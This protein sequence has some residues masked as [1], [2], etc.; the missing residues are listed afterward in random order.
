LEHPGIDGV[1]IFRNLL[2]F[3][4]DPLKSFRQGID[5]GIGGRSPGG[6]GLLWRMAQSEKGKGKENI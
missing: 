2:Q 1:D 5:A 6:Q 3:S 4:L